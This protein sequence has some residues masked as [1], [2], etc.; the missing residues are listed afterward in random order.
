[1]TD[2]GRI[3]V[4]QRCRPRVRGEIGIGVEDVD[5]N[6]LVPKGGADED[7]IKHLGLSEIDVGVAF[8]RGKILEDVDETCFT[9][10]VDGFSII[11]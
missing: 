8:L 3:C 11:V 10:G 9:E 4:G 1:M 2:H 7:V 6:G 5:R